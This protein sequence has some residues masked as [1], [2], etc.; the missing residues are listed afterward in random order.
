[1]AIAKIPVSKASNANG[2]PIGAAIQNIY[3]LETSLVNWLAEYSVGNQTPDQ[4]QL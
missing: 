4:V 1:M 3:S 2:D